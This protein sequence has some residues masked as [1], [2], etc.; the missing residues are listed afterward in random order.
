MKSLLFLISVI[1]FFNSTI[2]AQTRTT[3]AVMDLSAAGV[4]ET[5]AQVI[6]SRLRA[7]LFNTEKF[8]VLEREKMEDILKEQG[9]QLSGCT[10]SECAVEA[11]QLMGVKQ[12]VAGE[13]GKVGNL[14]VLTI[15]L[16]D[17]ETGKVIKTATED[18]RC[19]IETVV[20]QSVKNV[21]QNISGLEVVL[22]ESVIKSYGKKDQK[23]VQNGSLSD[24]VSVKSSG[25]AFWLSF[26]IPGTG[27]YYNG[28]IG[29]GIIHNLM[30]TSGIL[31]VSGGT[32]NV[33]NEVSGQKLR[34]EKY[35]WYYLGVGGIIG[36]WIW[37]ILDARSSDVDQNEELKK[38]YKL[39]FTPKLNKYSKQPM[40]GV[41]ISF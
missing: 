28:D 6:T 10:S 3:I 36:T 22:N 29:L 13:I 27:Q 30:L 12:M 1:T 16:I 34:E 35:Y 17:V 31:A 24:S 8:I 39:S 38:K 2:L 7:D 14:Y 33:Y 37:S 40:L 23:A 18:C 4:A 19:D 41:N 9:F 11:G 26:F 15:R 20:T 21:A 32:Y 5:D 25:T